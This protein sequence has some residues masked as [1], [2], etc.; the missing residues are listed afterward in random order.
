M[1][2]REAILR[3]KLTVKAGYF[4][5]FLLVL[6][7]LFRSLSQSLFFSRPDRLNLIFYSQTPYVLSLGYKDNINY[8][9]SFYPDLKVLVPGGYGYY[10]VGAIGK[11]ISLEKDPQ[12]LKRTFSSATSTFASLYFFKNQEEVYYGKKK[13]EDIR[14]PGLSEILFAKSNASFFDRAFLFY[15][16]ILLKPGDFTQLDPLVQ[17]EKEDTI[18]SVEDFAKEYQGFFYQSTYRNE[19]RSVQ[20]IYTKRTKNAELVSRIL[21]GSGIRVVDVSFEEEDLK[22]CLIIEGG[23][24]SRTA[25]ALSSFFGCRLIQ[26]QTR[27]S[28]I[29]FHLGSEEEH[30][31]HE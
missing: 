2:R 9:V 16:L 27:L 12:I 11:L 6:F 8:L 28:D 14:L 3:K 4:G 22:N 29:I 20:I 17:K 23:K 19:R 21:E 18:F 5:L 1:R 13:V 7:F 30:W 25:K 10:R 15:K 26:G 31:A 24:G